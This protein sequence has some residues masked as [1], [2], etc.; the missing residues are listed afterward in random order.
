M[1]YDTMEATQD[2]EKDSSMSLV[3]ST[4]IGFL[5]IAFLIPLLYNISHINI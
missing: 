4:L 2:Q 5:G 1:K 3:L